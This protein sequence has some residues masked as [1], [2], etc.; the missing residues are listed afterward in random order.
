MKRKKTDGLPVGDGAVVEAAPILAGKPSNADQIENKAALLQDATVNDAADKVNIAASD[1]EAMKA[2]K[3]DAKAYISSKGKADGFEI[4]LAKYFANSG[5]E[6]KGEAKAYAALGF[7]NAQSFVEDRLSTILGKDKEL[8]GADEKKRFSTIRNWIVNRLNI[9]ALVKAKAER[10]AK[11][12]A[13]REAGEK[14]EEDKA[15]SQQ[16]ALRR[17]TAFE[18]LLRERIDYLEGLLV[19]N[20]VQF[21]E[22]S[23]DSLFFAACSAITKADAEK[24]EEKATAPETEA[25]DSAAGEK[26]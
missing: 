22:V 9:P 26:V 16:L 1:A 20:H 23:F 3:H 4:A 15:L 11:A 12:K 25:T 7:Q 5:I 21:N 24:P 17:G 10:A 14:S 19:A 13:T 8:L 6:M 18:G 2:L